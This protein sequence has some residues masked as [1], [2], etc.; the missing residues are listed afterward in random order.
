[1][2]FYDNFFLNKNIVFTR[3]KTW[4]YKLFVRKGLIFQKKRHPSTHGYFEQYRRRRFGPFPPS[5]FFTQENKN[6]E[7][8][9]EIR[10]VQIK[11]KSFTRAFCK[12]PKTSFICHFQTLLLQI[13][14]WRKNCVTHS[15][16]HR[17]FF[18][19]RLQR[20]K[21]IQELSE[22]SIRRF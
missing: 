1:M 20:K 21:F 16:H 22:M 11:E 19:W 5:S 6:R 15:S 12:S 14:R 13:W 4:V 2:N 17:L 8:L 9:D 3:K 10:M 7:N 18:P